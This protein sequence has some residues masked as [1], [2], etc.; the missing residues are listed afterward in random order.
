MATETLSGPL[1]EVR[2]ATAAA[3]LAI[4]TTPQFTQLPP[5]TDKVMMVARNFTTAV[6]AQIAMNPYLI[7]LKTTDALQSA[8]AATDYSSA[9]QDASIATDV[10]LSSLDTAANLDF[11]YVGAKWP[12]R[13]VSID[14]DSTNSVASVLTVKYWN[15]TAWGT[16]S[17]TDGTI[18]AATTMAVDGNVTWTVP[19]DWVHNSLTKIGDALGTAAIPHIGDDLYWT[20]WEVS[21]ALDS[22]T[23]L[24]SMLSMNRSTAYME[25]IPSQT[26]EERISVGPDGIGCVEARTDA[27]TANLIVNVATKAQSGFLS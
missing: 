18:S 13:G 15:G 23:T 21:V 2:S 25:L 20:R 4:T 22:S 14:V 11:L 19:T 10:V 3:G 5:G 1:G 8:A 17:A 26:F 16:I 12:F 9:A 27:G 7:V 24:N 6:V